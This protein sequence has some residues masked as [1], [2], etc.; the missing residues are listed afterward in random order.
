MTNVKELQEKIK[1]IVDLQQIPYQRVSTLTDLK[2][3]EVIKICNL[4]PIES[5]EHALLLALQNLNFS[6]KSL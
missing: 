2:L 1:S 6:V 4:E 3:E 5:S